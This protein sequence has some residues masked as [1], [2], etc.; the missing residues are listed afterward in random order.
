MAGQR[1][2]SVAKCG[3]PTVGLGFCKNHYYRYRKYGNPLAGSTAPG[4][5]LKYLETVVI[6]YAVD[7]CLMWPYARDSNGYGQV[8]IGGKAQY[9]TRV[10]CERV[11]GDPPSSRHQAAHSCG[12][13]HEGCCSPRHLRWATVRENRADKK[14]H[15][16]FKRPPIKPTLTPDQVRQIRA[17]RGRYTQRQIAVMFGVTHCTVGAI[18]RGTAWKDIE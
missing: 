3:K 5:P 18:H 16:T 14:V 1:I 17:L 2:C 12:N 8:R 7:D 6:P 15:G 13:G 10:V 4:E 9:V 11:H